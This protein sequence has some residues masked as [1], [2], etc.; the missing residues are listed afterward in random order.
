VEQQQEDVV[1]SSKRE[2]RG[3]KT[4]EK[5]SL[6]N[7]RWR[8]Y[9]KRRKDIFGDFYRIY[10]W[11][12]CGP[13]AVELGGNFEKFSAR[14]LLLCQ[15]ED[16]ENNRVPQAG[17]SCLQSRAIE[18]W[19]QHSTQIHRGLHAIPRKIW[20]FSID[21]VNDAMTSFTS[22]ERENVEEDSTH[23]LSR[24]SWISVRVISIFGGTFGASFDFWCVI[25]ESKKEMNG[26]VICCLIFLKFYSWIWLS[27]SFLQRRSVLNIEYNH[28]VSRE[29]NCLLSWHFSIIAVTEF[30]TDLIGT[31]ALLF[32]LF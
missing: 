26:E 19:L 10:R 24:L 22:C 7:G 14:C 25:G 17:F 20:K 28:S 32:D 27:K 29:P 31:K 11:R 9:A 3:E 6:I 1:V 21:P 5:V 18:N 12:F 13:K 8:K 16:N 2:T 23:K 15:A 30:Q 4:S